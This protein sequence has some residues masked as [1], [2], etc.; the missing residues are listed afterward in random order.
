ML[1]ILNY[2]IIEVLLK[3]YI[4]NKALCVMNINSENLNW[5][6][7]VKTLGSGASGCVYRVPVSFNS[8]SN[9]FEYV[10][11]KKVNIN[12]FALFLLLFTDRKW[13]R[14]FKGNRGTKK[15]LGL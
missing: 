2:L 7:K 5:D 13:K 10:A 11:I 9:V 15:A 1:T 3:I 6:N 4:S 14:I 8:V 12:L